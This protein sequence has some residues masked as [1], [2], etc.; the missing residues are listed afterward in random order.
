M[1][2]VLVLPLVGILAV[3]VLAVPVAGCLGPEPGALLPPPTTDVKPGA[4]DLFINL[5]QDGRGIETFT[6]ANNE[7]V[8][9]TYRF[10]AGYGCGGGPIVLTV[11]PGEAALAPGESVTLRIEA[12]ASNT[13]AGGAYEERVRVIAQTTGAS[14][15]RLDVP[16]IVVVAK[17]APRALGA[18]AIGLSVAAVA[19]AY[20]IV[21]SLR[22]PAK[23]GP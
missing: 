21:R 7:G 19:S 8:D 18:V 6:F 15:A 14:P 4:A 9:A 2:R 16:D 11:T 22:L 13:G 5:G 3:V 17:T 1:R 10:R 20:F 23:P 12:V